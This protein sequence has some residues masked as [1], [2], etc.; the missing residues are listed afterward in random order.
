MTFVDK[1]LAVGRPAEATNLLRRAA[2]LAREAE[3]LPLR[4]ASLSRIAVAPGHSRNSGPRSP[5][6]G[7][8]TTPGSTAWHATG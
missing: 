3:E 7:P 5:C 2:A 4:A 8:A 6:P 1:H